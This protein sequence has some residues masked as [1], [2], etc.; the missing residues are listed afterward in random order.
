[1]ELKDVR[2]LTGSNYLLNRAGAA[3]E[4]VVEPDEGGD[5]LP[6]FGNLET[7]VRRLLKAV[8]WEYEEVVTR[9][10][11]G[12]GSIYITAPIDA[13]Y[14]ATSLIEAAWDIVHLPVDASKDAVI[15]KYTEKLRAEISGEHH[16]DL[17]SLRDEAL[18]RNIAFLSDDDEVSLGLGRGRQIWNTADIPKAENVNWSKIDNIPV[19]LVTGTNGKSTTVRLASAIAA[20]AGYIVASSSSDYVRVGDVILDEG[21]YSGPGGARMAL[22]DPRADMAILET[23]RGGLMRRGLPIAN[24]DVCLITNISA[25]HLGEYGITNVPALAD[26]K[27]MLSKAVS[28]QGRLILNHDDPELVK[29][30][31]NF[32]GK[33]TWYGLSMAEDFLKQCEARGEHAV[34]VQNGQ[35]MLMTSGP[36]IPVL[37]ISDFP[38]S[39][40]GAA[41]F[42]VSNGLGAI[43]LTSALGIDVDSMAG[44]LKDF[45][46]TP[47]S[48]PGRGNFLTVGGTNILLDFAHNPDGVTALAEMVKAVPAKRRLFLLGQAGD[49]SDQDIQ[50]M[51]KAVHAADPDMIIVKELP[52]KLR[53]RELGAVPAI[54]LKT[55]KDLN[56]PGAQIMQ[57]ECEFTAARLALKWAKP[58]D[59]L[60]FLVYVDRQEVLD[61][62]YQLKEVG[63]TCGDPLP[64]PDK[65]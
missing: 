13:L 38:L 48:N 11:S 5:V 42:N 8:D 12:G 10:Y 63:W 29:R 27:F 55:L 34:F 53:G 65:T 21:D 35:M 45:E 17:I 3:A 32:E 33:V 39:M 9:I 37:P 22:R 7:C 16:P 19:A 2:R 30:A 47:E 24:I 15:Q 40:G 4:I 1:M 14:A 23:A 25:D 43:A 54:I 56:V 36:S 62:V 20:E 44:A 57:A 6:V 51:T 64:E 59:L 49:R 50:D 52:T 26:A 18:E 28:P 41:T 46:S 61:Y 60:V 31:R 58:D